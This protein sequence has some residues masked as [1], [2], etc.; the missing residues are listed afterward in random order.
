[1]VRLNRNPKKYDYKLSDEPG[2]DEIRH[3]HSTAR[4]QDMLI[5]TRIKAL[6]AEID[7]LEDLELLQ[8]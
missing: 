7:E 8:G 2:L 3:I 6:Q 1:M 5:E 4:A